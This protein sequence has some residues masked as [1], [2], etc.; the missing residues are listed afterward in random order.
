MEA[1]R[2]AREELEDVKRRL[3]DNRLRW[4]SL[5]TH[6]VT[7]TL[8]HATSGNGPHLECDLV[9]VRVKIRKDKV[10][11][12][13]YAVTDGSCQ[14]DKRADRRTYSRTEI[15]P[16]DLFKFIEDSLEIPAAGPYCGLIVTYHATL[17]IPTRIAGG[18]CPGM[19]PD[20]DPWMIEVSDITVAR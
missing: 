17:G 14:A 7:Y 1:R 19:L 6:D 5:A 10:A 15:T 11:S 9:P 3:S 12:V 20:D 8:R 4:N 18:G 2:I 16:W 13:R